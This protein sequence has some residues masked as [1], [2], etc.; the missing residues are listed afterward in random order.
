MKNSFNEDKCCYLTVNEVVEIIEKTV[1]SSLQENWDNSGIQIC[2]GNDN[3][4]KILTCLE[5][6]K[7]ILHEALENEVNMIVSHHPLIF[8]GIKKFNDADYDSSIIMSLINNRI[9]VYSSH[10]SFDKI[11]G[12]NNDIVAEKIGLL[13][14]TNLKGEGIASPQKMIEANSDADIGRIGEF[15][16]PIKFKQVIEKVS[17]GLELSIRQLRIT[18]SLD[19]EISKVGICTGAGVDL[20]SMA[21][22]SGCD[23][24]ITGDIKHHEAHE[25]IQNDKCLLDAGHYGTEKFFADAMKHILKK[26]LG[27]GID[28][29]T[30]KTSTDPFIIL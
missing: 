8:S 4:T 15:K 16:S 21:F 11:K 3:V 26:E 18:G 28:V 13:S 17:E 7:E 20:A 24:F 10:T 2:F 5:I 27:N 6:N 14:L 23:L 1:P 22:E 12:G 29:I 25:A 19:R 30:A 9:S